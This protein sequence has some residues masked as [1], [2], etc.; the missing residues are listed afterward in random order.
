M[1]IVIM[2]AIIPRGEVRFVPIWGK[3]A[4]VTVVMNTLGLFWIARGAYHSKPSNPGWIDNPQLSL[5][6]ITVHRA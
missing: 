4:N 2:I 1:N 5:E 6:L 3:D